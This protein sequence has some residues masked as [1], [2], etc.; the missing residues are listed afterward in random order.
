MTAILLCK[1]LKNGS[2]WQ[3]T[4]VWKDSVATASG[5]APAAFDAVIEVD[6][7]REERGR[8]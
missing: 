7:Q 1:Y 4:T 2:Q 6:E 5:T 8:A 3:S